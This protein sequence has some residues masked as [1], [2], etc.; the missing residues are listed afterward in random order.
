MVL[1]IRLLP[2]IYVGCKYMTEG[3][4]L[5]HLRP[6]RYTEII[7]RVRYSV[8]DVTVTLVLSSPVYRHRH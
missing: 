4:R 3:C 5:Q 7:L 2:S 6:K 8:R 1:Y